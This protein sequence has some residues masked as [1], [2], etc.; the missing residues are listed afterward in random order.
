MR[1]IMGLFSR[2]PFGPLTEHTERVREA[3]RLVRPLFEAFTAGDWDRTA[4]INEQ[5]SKVEHKADLLK[6]DI[7]DHLPRSIFLPVDRSDV[8]L[9]LK[10]QDRL[11]DRAEDL[12][13]LLNMRRTPTPEGM[14][15]ETLALVDA[16][17]LAAEKWFDTALEIPMLQEASFAGPEVVKVMDRIK[18]VSDLEW[19]ADKRSATVS[20]T[21]FQY[22][23]EIGAIS[24]MLWM[25]II[26][27]LAQIAD[28]AENSADL[29]RLMLARR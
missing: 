13:V 6:N 12:G 29:L 3:V 11:A 2:S 26:R 18:E 7:R 22:E 14:K 17:V 27:V 4:E 16:V 15:E 20:R 23:G 5:I 8:L 1:S 9:L 25:S 10:E 21:L 24:I 19:E 28:H